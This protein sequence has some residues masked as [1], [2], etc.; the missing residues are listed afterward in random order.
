MNA[1]AS[2]LHNIRVVLVRP[3]YGG[4]V[5]AVCRAMK[6]MGVR[7][8]ALVNPR[9]DMNW[10]EARQRAYRALDVLEG[11][12]RFSSLVE[13]VADCGLVAGTSVRP[14]LY[15]EHAQTPRDCAPRL[16]AAAADTSVAL[17][18]GP[19]DS[20]LT[21]EEI[22]LCTQIIRI[23][24]SEEY[25]SLNL[26]HA[27]MVI[28]YEL[29]LAAGEF[30]PPAERSPEAP[31]QLRERMFAMWREALLNIGFMDQQKADHM[32]MGLRRILSRGP[33]TVADIKI[34]MGIA[35]QANWCGIQ[36]RHRGI[37]PEKKT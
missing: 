16:L 13:A 8:L 27:V 25:P 23:P 5:G 17:V 24:S 10:D 21:N 7:D 12:R 3:V 36:L 20:G 6:N 19:E 22:A 18:F 29:F 30:E 35:R 37:S 4:N 2:K 34:L 15:R 14:G 1:L 28:C 33:L 9:N 31:S 11:H 26:S 32:M